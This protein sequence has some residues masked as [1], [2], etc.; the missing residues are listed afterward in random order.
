M[1][2][3]ALYTCKSL[4]N[5]RKRSEFYKYFRND[6][7]ATRIRPPA[8]DEDS[9]HETAMLKLWIRIKHPY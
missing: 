6:P 3:K 2:E 7:R 5:C 8:M 9:E 1:M 4:Q